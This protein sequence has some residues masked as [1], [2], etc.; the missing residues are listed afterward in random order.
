[1]K[2]LIP[3]FALLCLSLS[4]KAQEIERALFE[5][6]DVIFKEVETLEGFKQSFL[7]EVKQPIDHSDSKSDFFYQ[8]VWL[9]VKDV[10]AFNVM[11]TEGYYAHNNYNFELT[12]LLNANQIIVEHRYFGNS[13][14]NSKNYDYLNLTQATAD[15]HKI[16]TLLDEFLKNKW[17]S[18]G[19]S[20]GGSTTIAYRYFYPDD[21]TVS[22]PYVAPI[23]NAYE[24]ERIYAF[25][26]TVGTDECRK[27]I[28]AFQTEMLKKKKK[29]LPLIEIKT[30]ESGAQFKYLGLEAAFEYAVM[31]YPFSFWQWGASC[32]DIP[33][34]KVPIEEKV[35]YLL[36]ISGLDFFG[37]ASIEYFEPHY[38][39]SAN[40][41]GYYGYETSEFKKF[42]TA[43]PTDRNPMAT[44]VP[45][46]ENIEFNGATLSEINSWLQEDANQMLYIYGAKDTWSATGVPPNS[47]VD[48]HWFIIKG[49]HHGNAR[50]WNMSENQKSRFIEALEKYLEVDLD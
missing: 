12:S 31:E 49:A 45:N 42:I 27:K 48:S 37:D 2:K 19:V 35:N 8:K 9:S 47:Q 46:Q 16:R 1:M 43:L 18:T 30:N 38:Y 28:R 17:I 3:F 26:D 10:K 13:R 6:P 22:V 40:E 33:A 7:L 41:M 50:I 44:F 4:L 25:F 20:K 21:V 11:I 36:S 32:D 14:P 39:Q 29:V 24:D 15:L 34:K 23:N 5:L